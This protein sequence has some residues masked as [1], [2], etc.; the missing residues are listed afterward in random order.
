MFHVFAVGSQPF[1]FCEIRF[2]KNQAQRREQTGTHK[3]GEFA[4]KDEIE[5]RQEDRRLLA[6]PYEKRSDDETKTRKALREA[7][8]CIVGNSGPPKWKYRLYADRAWSP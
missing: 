1:S 4:G 8:W 3:A 5:I 6:Q 2:A 7:G